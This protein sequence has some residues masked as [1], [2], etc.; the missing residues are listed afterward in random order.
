MGPVF[1]SLRRRSQIDT[2]RPGQAKIG[3]SEGHLLARLSR[4]RPPLTTT[5][6]FVPQALAASAG[7]S[8]AP[9]FLRRPL[10]GAVHFSQ[11]AE[12]ATATTAIACVPL[13]AS[14]FAAGAAFGSQRCPRGQLRL[15][16]LKTRTYVFNHLFHQM[17]RPQAVLTTSLAASAMAG[18]CRSRV[19]A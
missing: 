11:A 17:A 8:R 14:F 13:L 3:T 7:V 1:G 5:P 2:T 9:S 19:R 16:R 18:W 15:S 12:A 10:A 6:T 4:A